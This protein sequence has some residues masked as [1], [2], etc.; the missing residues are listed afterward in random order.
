MLSILAR[1]ISHPIRIHPALWSFAEECRGT[2]VRLTAYVGALALIATA[3]MSLW[4]ELPFA[5]A[6]EPAAKAGWSMAGRSHPAFA[7]SQ[8]DSIEKTEAYEI[9]RHPE[10]GR[11]DVLRWAATTTEKPIAELELYRPGTEASQAGPPAD[12]IAARM[13]PD[14]MR[15]IA[16]EGIVDSKFGPV[17]L[18]G[19]ADRADDAKRCLGFMKNL[20][21]ANLRISGWSCQGETLPARRL[22]IACTLN[23]L[24]LLTAG[25]DPKL[26]EL[27]ASAELKRASC[28]SGNAA[29]AS[30]ADWV[31]GAQ[32]PRLRGS[33]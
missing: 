25:T 22:A 17:A 31:T 27:F 6:L 19:F 1:R 7:V 13:D 11:K 21:A 14:G 16:G 23:R 3:C 30:S 10:G 4:D 24:T 20:E 18:F 15:Q 32:N 9:F 33:L 2:T 5:A 26:A 28:A 29:T 12:E 8:V